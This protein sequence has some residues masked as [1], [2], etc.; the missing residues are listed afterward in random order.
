MFASELKR[1]KAFTA[2]FAVMERFQVI[3]WAIPAVA[4]IWLLAARLHLH[5]KAVAQTTQ[6]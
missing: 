2:M 6:K 5:K 3:A 1:S 4:A